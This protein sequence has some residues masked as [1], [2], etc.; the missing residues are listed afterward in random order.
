MPYVDRQLPYMCLEINN[1][2]RSV[3]YMVCWAIVEAHEP[4]RV[5]RQFGRTPFIP[6][7]RDWIS[8]KI[9]SKQIVRKIEKGLG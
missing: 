3:T 5:V 6:E 8:M 7:M 4:E 1:T 9:T 2:W